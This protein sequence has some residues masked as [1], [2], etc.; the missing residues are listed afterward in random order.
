MHQQ[1]IVLPHDDPAKA[2]P[3][4][5][6]VRRKA[7]KQ[8]VMA[9]Y[10][11]FFSNFIFAALTVIIVSGLI[12]EI[13]KQGNGIV[14][15]T[16]PQLM[17][18]WEKLSGIYRPLCPNLISLIA[19]SV[20]FL[21]LVSFCF[22]GLVALLILAVYHPRRIS[23]P[24]E[25]M[26]EASH[27]LLS[28]ARD[29]RRYSLRAS[30]TSGSMLWSMVFM[31]AALGLFGYYLATEQLTMEILLEL[32]TKP[33]MPLLEPFIKTELAYFTVKHSLFDLMLIVYAFGFYLAYL[34]ANTLHMFSVHFFFRYDVPYSFVAQTEHMH[35]FNGQDIEA[36][37]DNAPQLLEQ[38]LEYEQM[39]AYQ[40]AKQLLAEAAHS[41]NAEAM[42]HYAR[43][44]LVAGASDPGKYWL[45]KYVA[46]AES[47]TSQA[48]RDLRRL[49][50]RKRVRAAY[51]PRKKDFM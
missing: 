16:I 26:Q 21:Y 46:Q 22:N 14:L 9:K 41:G 44:W 17:Q 35:I 50:W 38:A 27:Q 24:E 20:F 49:K 45:E 11:S 31:L 6:N 28:M 43:H 8:C 1:F 19:A 42:G 15:H 37:A 39:G 7:K 40:K 29:A 3:L 10:A 47:P 13:P 30:S 5:D 4:V 36:V 2:W 33:A 32:L 48:V 18:L 51:L 34:A 23:F 25:G 12:Y